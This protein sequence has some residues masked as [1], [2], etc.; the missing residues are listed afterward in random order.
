MSH[1]QSMF[2]F[3]HQKLKTTVQATPK[4][5]YT[6]I[7]QHQLFM[8][9]LQTQRIHMMQAQDLVSEQLMQQMWV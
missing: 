8:Q 2:V 6:I 3:N 5:A 9:F 4:Q 7:H 1:Q